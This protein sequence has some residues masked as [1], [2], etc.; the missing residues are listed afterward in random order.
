MAS[1]GSAVARRL[2]SNP[3][4][5]L[6]QHSCLK[7]ANYDR[8]AKLCTDNHLPPPCV[9]WDRPPHSPLNPERQPGTYTA[10]S[11]ADWKIQLQKSGVSANIEAALQSVAGYPAR[12]I[13]CATG[14]Y[15]PGFDF[16]HHGVGGENPIRTN[17]PARLI[18]LVNLQFACV[19]ILR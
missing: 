5:V 3:V 18:T 8:V 2:S 13:Y 17:I 15:P 12:A 6:R 1:H 7:N 19:D 9:A 11:L 16:T 4:S 10:Q 14:V